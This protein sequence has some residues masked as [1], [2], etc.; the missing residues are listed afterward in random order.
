MFKKTYILPIY[1]TNHKDKNIII[2]NKG[3]ILIF[4]PIIYCIIIF[5]LYII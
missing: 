1:Y 5:Y 3:D 4:I 2:C